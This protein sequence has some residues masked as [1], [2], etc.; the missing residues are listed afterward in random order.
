MQ[1]F[2]AGHFSTPQNLQPEHLRLA[3]FVLENNYVECKG[4][5]GSFL[6]RIGTA[7]GTSFSVTYATFYMNWLETPII[8]EFQQHVE[9]HKR[10]IDDS[11]LMVY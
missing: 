9:M 4:I 3:R 10:Y 11:I 7:M 2:T 6:Q 1:W 8:N 5:E